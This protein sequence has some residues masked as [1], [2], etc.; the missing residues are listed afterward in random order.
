MRS[1]SDVVEKLKDALAVHGREKMDTAAK[2]LLIVEGTYALNRKAAMTAYYQQMASV[3]GF[4]T[5]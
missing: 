3:G 5:Q 2:D 4:E 1:C